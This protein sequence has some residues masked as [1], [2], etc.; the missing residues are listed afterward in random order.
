MV[1]AAGEH[2]GA[3]VAGVDAVD[4]VGDVEAA[5]EAAK[6]EGGEDVLDGGSDAALRGSAGWWDWPP[7]GRYS[8]S[9][10]SF[11]LLSFWVGFGYKGSFFY[12]DV[13]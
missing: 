5:G 4:E 6:V 3:V 10:F 13:Q 8:P 11:C 1:P 7:S 12:M 9:G 2:L